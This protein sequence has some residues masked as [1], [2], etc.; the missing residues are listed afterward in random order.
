MTDSFIHLHVHASTSAFDGLGTAKDFAT[1]AAEIGQSALALS[2]H[3]SIR[4]LYEHHVACTKIGIKPIAA[5]EA[6]FSEDAT[7]GKLTQQ[8]RDAIRKLHGVDAPPRIKEIDA[9]RKDR[10]HITIWAM[11]QE[12]VKNLYR[13]QHWAW[14]TGLWR[15]HRRNFARVDMPRLK[16][17]AAGLA[18][19]TGCP[20]GV[21]ARPL[22]QGDTKLALARMR[23]LK[24]AFG[25]RV[26]IEV[27][28]HLPHE[29]KQVDITSALVAMSRRF[30]APIIATQDAH[31]PSRSDAAGQDALL[32][33]NTGST[34][35]DPNRFAF[36]APDYWLRTRVEMKTA[37]AEKLPS[38]GGKL[39]EE[40][41]D[42]TCR[43]ADRVTGQIQLAPQGAY[44]VAPALPPEHATYDAW[45]K[46]LVLKGIQERGPRLTRQYADRIYLELGRL[47]AGGYAAYFC[48][49]LDTRRWAQ[50]NGVLC[51]P[52]RGS[53]GGS[54]VAYL[55]GIHDVD[56]IK[57]DLSFDRFL[58]PGGARVDLPDIDADVEMGRRGD[59]IQYIRQTYGEDRVAHI[60]TH[61]TF[62]GKKAL[63]DLARV[64]G[65]SEAE[66][67]EVAQLVPDT[68]TEED[69]AGASA[70]DVLVETSVGRAFAEKYPDAAAVVRRLE[71]QLRDVG[72]HAAGIVVSSVP[73]EDIVPLEVSEG[74][75]TVIAWGM[76]G[77]EAA[78]LVKQDWLGLSTL[79]IVRLAAGR[80]GI[81]PADIPPDDPASMAA[82]SA[83]DLV[84]VF[85]FDTPSARKLCQGFQFKGLLDV[86]AMTALNRPG[87][88]LS[89]LADQF[90]DGAADPSTIPARHLIYDD[91][92]R[93]TYGVL[94]YQE[95][96]VAV[97]TRLGGFDAR[98]ADECRRFMSKKKAGIEKYRGAFVDG[99]I[100]NEMSE[101]S[102]SNL[103]DDLTNF[104]KYCFNRSH[105]VSYALLSVWTQY[106]KIHHPIQFYA[107]ALQ[108]EDNEQRRLRLAADARRR[109]LVVAPPDVRQTAPGFAVVVDSEPPEIVGSIDSI[110]GVGPKVADLVTK[111]AP[112]TSAR[113]FYEK[114]ADNPAVNVRVFEA[115]CR[116]T[117]FRHLHPKSTG[118][119]VENARA[120]WQ[121]FQKGDDP[122]I[123]IDKRALDTDALIQSVATLW[124]M[125]AD[126]DN[127]GLFDVYLGQVL[128]LSKR[129]IITPSDKAALDVPN[130]CHLVFAR[131][132]KKSLY[133]A[134]YGEG[135]EGRLVL[136]DSAGGEI[137]VRADQA[138]LDQAGNAA[139]KDGAYGLYLLRS[140]RRA[141]R[142]SVEAAWSVPVVDDPPVALLAALGRVSSS[143]ANLA[144][145]WA[146]LDD[147]GTSRVTATVVYR[148]T[149]QDKN[150]NPMLA[151]GIQARVGYLRVFVWASMMGDKQLA[152]LRPG[153]R[154][155]MPL[156]K[157][158][159]GTAAL[160]RGKVSVEP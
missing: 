92:T 49:V 10:A 99:A 136:A 94:V 27:M 34:M 25:D 130:A 114:H 54:C 145:N 110:K 142:P 85:Q 102:A 42:E 61:I 1:K 147:G 116:V 24:D 41:L 14:T 146:K 6:Y 67:A 26:Y 154:I 64:H 107:A 23:A 11:T 86:A 89:G 112:Y 32:C 47:C 91:I 3:G 111:H 87:P 140:G 37:F 46:A 63:R 55:I 45:L 57:Y 28:P 134:R 103:F 158:D 8:E 48:A 125:F 31:Y 50:Q 155:S 44:F 151:L 132:Q 78:G 133:P 141:G 105:S 40:A 108:I 76:K 15:G 73:I 65:I 119:L 143:P 106:L 98:T 127:R 137:V 58:P 79:D 30:D 117:A 52:G 96:V 68:L 160:A 66:V 101:G 38:V 148:T 115:L 35:D 97:L 59:V 13:L 139:S 51:G 43:F 56:P 84:G 72:V 157:L 20:Q 159:D 149:R 77:A 21:V 60:Q 53:V 93:E 81:V 2:D 29:A 4:G 7:I 118:W 150:H 80:A 74:G 90:L 121:L 144:A 153:L 123:G 156:E 71:G 62:K 17:F 36:D 120:L 129:P 75:E 88:L 19:S 83:G 95:Q 5:V 39:L 122:K 33:I 12:G 109:G 22:H 69:V 152:L 104:A 138:A 128:D 18:V 113:D 70:A 135:K 9:E 131:L 100:I 124:P 126:L 16:Q 82:F